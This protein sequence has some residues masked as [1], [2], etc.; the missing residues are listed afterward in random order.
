MFIVLVSHFFIVPCIGAE[1]KNGGS[2]KV[3]PGEGK[4]LHLSQ[5]K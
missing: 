4:V 3:Q 1:I 5:V 2:L